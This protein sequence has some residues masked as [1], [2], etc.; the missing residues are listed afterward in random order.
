M[1]SA[2]VLAGSADLAFAHPIVRA[3][4][5]ETIGSEERAL[6]HARAAALLAAEAAPPDRLALHLLHTHPRGDAQVVST[7]RAAA[8]IAVSRGAPDSAEAY[9]RRAQKE[10]PP[11]AL[12]GQLLLELG[13]AEMAVDAVHGRLEF[14]EAVATIDAPPERASAAL[15][16]GRALGVAGYFQE[17]A[18]VLESVPD[19][20]P[21]FVAELAANGCQVAGHVPAALS[22]LAHCRDSNH[23]G[24]DGWHLLQVMLHTGAWPGE[25]A[26]VAAEMLD[27]ALAEPELFAEESLVAVYAAMNLVMIHRLDEAERLVR[28]IHRGGATP[29]RASIVTTFAFPRA[30]ASL[31]RGV[32][33]EAE[34]DA[35]WSFER[36]L[37][38]AAEAPSGF[39][40]PLAFLVEA[41]TELGAFTGAE[42]A[43]AR[44]NG[45]VKSRPDAGVGVRARG[46]RATSP[47]AGTPARRA[48]RPA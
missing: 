16:A 20:D 4:A 35:R 1:R 18:A 36:K 13:L 19:P 27:R 10:P 32:L 15:L 8:A 22:S 48:A 23:P 47:R 14:R 29:R 38:T 24:C 34:G 33:R 17:A 5:E 26:S 31:R 46:S 11:Q 44:A 12:R 25:P 9:L 6:A 7:L 3:A 37:A 2:S 42:D 41:L 40:W 28:R 30:F 21:R 43:L 39:A 45:L